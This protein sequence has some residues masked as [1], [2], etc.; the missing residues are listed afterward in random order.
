MMATNSI[1][2]SGCVCGDLFGI[3]LL[4]TVRSQRLVGVQMHF[5]GLIEFSIQ[6]FETTASLAHVSVK[7]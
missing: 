5:F 6:A 3:L 4:C 1:P 2:N 7:I